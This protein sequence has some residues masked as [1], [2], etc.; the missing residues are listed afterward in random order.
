MY[1]CLIQNVHQKQPNS[2][3]FLHDTARPQQSVHELN[4]T[5]T[6][7]PND[8][9]TNN[10]DALPPYLA[11]SDSGNVTASVVYVSYGTLADFDCLKVALA[12]R[13]NHLLGPER[14]GFVRG[15]VYPEGIYRPKG[16]FQC[17]SLQYLSLASGDPLTPGWASVQG[18]P[19]LKYEDVDS[20]PHIPALPFSYEQ[21]DIILRSI[22]GQKGSP[23]D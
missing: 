3:R 15:E 16:S 20:I 1:M 2:H 10:S 21:A 9:C 4:L 5:E 14:D 22:G 12:E 18:A 19:Q 11:Y 6:S 7:V 23:E 17:G 8:A 13:S